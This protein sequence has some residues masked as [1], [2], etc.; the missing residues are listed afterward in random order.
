MGLMHL[1]LCISCAVYWIHYSS[2]FG[3]VRSYGGLTIQKEILLKIINVKINSPAEEMGIEPGDDLLTVNGHPVRDIL[4]YHFYRDSDKL[5]L[6]IDRKGQTFIFE[7]ECEDGFKLG[8]NLEEMSCK[9]CGNHCVFCFVDQNPADVRPSLLF[10]DEDYRMSFLY[11]NYVTL[12]NFTEKDLQ[13][14]AEQRLSPLYISVHAL[15]EN[16]R[17][18]MLGLHKPDRF[19]EKLGYLAEHEIEMHAQIVLCPGWNDGDVFMDTVH[20]LSVY[21][22]WIKTVAIVPVGLTKHR[23]NLPFIEPVT[24][25]MAEQ[26][27]NWAECQAARFKSKLKSY[28]IYLADEFYILV[29]H[30]LPQSER[31][32]DFSQIENGVGMTRRF[33]ESFEE[34]LPGLPREIQNVKLLLVTG[35]LASGVLADTVLPALNR[36]SGLSASLHIVKNTFFGGGVTVSGLLTGADI[37]NSFADAENAI[38]ILPPNCLNYNHVFLDDWTV[39]ELSTA[40]QRPVYQFRH[41]FTELLTRV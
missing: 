38:V 35:E 14:I 36:I 27:I 4:D 30:D 17:K 16:V 32:D 24:P 13:R 9:G 25:E 2:I 8:L 41:S 21:Y 20:R 18:N 19:M 11:G 1:E 23:N 33:L 29:D 22:P 37:A 12:T 15:D 5:E 31:Y 6:E 39:D 7:I 40:I 28:F 34:E 26:V 10:K 3:T